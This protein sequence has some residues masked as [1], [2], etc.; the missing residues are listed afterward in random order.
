MI[1]AACIKSNVPIRTNTT[2]EKSDTLLL[3]YFI[4]ILIA[5]LVNFENR[6]FLEFLLLCFHF[7]IAE[8]EINVIVRKYFKKMFSFSQYNFIRIYQLSLFNIKANVF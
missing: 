3:Y 5:P 2:Q 1:R 6:F 8:R 7:A 4:F